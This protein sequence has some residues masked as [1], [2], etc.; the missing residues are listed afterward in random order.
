MLM[1]MKIN[2]VRIFIFHE[3]GENNRATE[4]A[5]EYMDIKLNQSHN[6]LSNEDQ[7]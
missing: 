7:R 4:S 5:L 2:F 6:R 3:T 1:W